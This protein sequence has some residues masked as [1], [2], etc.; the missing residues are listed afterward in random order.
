MRAPGTRGLS[1]DANASERPQHTPQRGG[2]GLS[3]R[4][5]SLDRPR[6]VSKQVGHAQLGGDVECLRDPVAGHHLEQGR[7]RRNG[8]RIGRYIL[9]RT[10][11]LNWRRACPPNRDRGRPHDL[12]PPTPADR[13]VTSPAV[14]WSQG[15]SQPANRLGRPSAAQARGGRASARAGLGLSRHGPWADLPVFPAHGRPPPRGRSSRA[16]LRPQGLPWS[17]RSRRRI[18]GSRAR[19]GARTSAKPQHARQPRLSWRRSATSCRMVRPRVRPVR[20]PGRSPAL[21]ASWTVRRRGRC[22]TRVTLALTRAPVRR[23]CRPR[24]YAPL[25]GPSARVQAPVAHADH[26]AVLHPLAHPAPPPVVVHP[27]ATRLQGAGDHPRLACPGVRRRLPPRLGGPALGANAGAPRSERRVPCRLQHL[28][29]GGLEAPGEPG[30]DPQGAGPTPRRWDGRPPDGLGGLG[31]LQSGGSAHRPRVS[32]RTRPGRPRSSRRL[33]GHPGGGG[34][35][36]AHAGD[37]GPRAAAPEGSAPP[38]QRPRPVSQRGLQPLVCPGAARAASRMPCPR[39]TRRDSSSPARPSRGPGRAC[40]PPAWRLG[41]A[42]APPCGRG[43]PPARGRRRAA[44]ARCGR[45][46]SA[47]PA[48]PVDLDTRPLSQAQPPSCPCVDAGGITHTPGAEGGLRGHVPTRPGGTTPPLRCLCVA[49]HVWMGLPPDVT[50][51]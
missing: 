15:R 37:S 24:L 17:L 39:A 12:S 38:P 1:E 5:Q 28:P 30:R 41:L 14:R 25:Q 40:S 7:G 4:G 46:R 2:V 11:L 42:G 26:P 6:P 49:P 43:V 48:V 8:A 35:G 33:L 21:L 27:V 50:A 34:P 10:H 51:R 45:L 9:R 36:G 3:R 29:A 16:P 13:R 23:P 22:R 18:H 44:E 47:P 31:A 19:R 32:S 20:F